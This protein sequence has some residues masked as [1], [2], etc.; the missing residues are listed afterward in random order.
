MQHPLDTYQADYMERPLLR[1]RLFWALVGSVI[2]H[3]AVVLWFQMTH[4]GQFNAPVERLVPRIFNVKSI[5]IPVDAINGDENPNPGSKN[6]DQH[7]EAK[8]ALKPLTMPEERPSADPIEGKM[9]PTAAATPPDIVK[10]VPSERPLSSQNE[11]PALERV[12]QSADKE[13]ERELNSVS[14]SLLNK[15][16]AIVGQSPLIKLPPGQSGN[17]AESDKNGMAEANG[18]L[19]KL[20]GRGLRAGDGPVTM[21]GGALFEFG[22][23]ELRL[24]ATKQLEKLGMLIQKSPNVTF[25]IAGFTDSFGTAAFNQQLSQERADAVRTWLIQNMG[26]DPAH[27]QANGYGATNFLVAPK[28]VDMTSQ[29]SIEQEKL[30]EQPNR[31]VEIQFKIP[32]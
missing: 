13:I 7:P 8:P 21:P 5:T 27:I 2:I 12:Q 30:L 9:V 32:K 11:V 22:S 10:P 3:V 25:V 24:E 1:R 16:P 20:L 4:L 18:R 17:A 6:P 15:Q 31:R 26:A 29:A 14:A 28:P 19:D 23:A